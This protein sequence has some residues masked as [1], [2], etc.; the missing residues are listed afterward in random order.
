MRHAIFALP[1]FGLLIAC[2]PSETPAA[3]STCSS[4]GDE[5]SEMQVEVMTEGTG[6]TPSA[7]DTVRVHYHGQFLDGRVFDSSMNRGS[8]ATFPLN[9]VIP[10][11]TQGLQTMK[12][13]GKVCLTCPPHLAYGEQGSGPIPPNATLVF[14]VELLGV[15]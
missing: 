3:S 1:F 2:S 14:E 13:G 8:P 4:A 6:R 5:V 12:E 7:T 11:W 10:C 15:Q 9:R